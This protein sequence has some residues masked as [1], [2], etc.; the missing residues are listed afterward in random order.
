MSG[1]CSRAEVV[2]S[3][4]SREMKC[5]FM[6]YKNEDCEVAHYY[7]ENNKGWCLQTGYYPNNDCSGSMIEMG[8]YGTIYKKGHGTEGHNCG[9]PTKHLMRGN[10][11]EN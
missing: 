8:K 7:P 10:D 9:I 5:A 6:C 11:R 4:Q 3:F 2:D 1:W